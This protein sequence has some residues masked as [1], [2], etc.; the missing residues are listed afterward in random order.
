MGHVYNLGL[1]VSCDVSVYAENASEAKEQAVSQVE[2]GLVDLG[3][4]NPDADEVSIETRLKNA[5]KH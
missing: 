2:S 1:N 5:S 3:F 4:D